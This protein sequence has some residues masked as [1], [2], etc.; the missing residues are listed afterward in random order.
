MSVPFNSTK[1]EKKIVIK[2]FG[3]I[4]LQFYML[5]TFQMY[6]IGFK[7]KYLK[8]GIFNYFLLLKFAL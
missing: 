8:L 6:F 5:L 2:H 1:N 4:R 3:F 7:K